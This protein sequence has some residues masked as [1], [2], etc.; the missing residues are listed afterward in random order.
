MVGTNSMLIIL[1]S[2]KVYEQIHRSQ[3]THVTLDILL[4]CNNAK[5]EGLK[6]YV[7][8]RSITMKRKISLFKS[9]E[10]QTIEKS[11]LYSTFLGE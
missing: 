3:Y 7:T 11:A 4:Y 1:L 10:A 5:K 9:E 6:A 8:T 2:K